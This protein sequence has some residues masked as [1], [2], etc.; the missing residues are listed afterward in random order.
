[1]VRKKVGII[2]IVSNNYGNRLQNYALQEALKRIGGVEPKTIPLKDK[3][4]FQRWLV[5][6]IKYLVDRFIKPIPNITWDEFNFSFI[7][8][9]EKSVDSHKKYLNK[10]YEYFIAGSDQIW[11][12]YFEFVSDRE[13]LMFTTPGK[14]IAYAASIGID[15][16]PEEHVRCYADAW[17]EFRYISV[18][19][20]AAAK[21]IFGNTGQSVDVVLDPTML[22][23]DEEW[24]QF[25]QKSMCEI[26]KKYCLKY[27]LGPVTEEYDRYIENYAKSS[28][29][30]IID[31]IYQNRISKKELSPTDFV[32]LIYNSQAVFTDSFHGS[33]FSII[34]R[35]PLA[36]FERP[37][38][39][40]HGVM[41]SRLDTL[42]ETFHLESQRAKAID[43]LENLHLEWNSENIDVI[44]EKKRIYAIQWL[45]NA[46]NK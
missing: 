15:T 43:D 11:N 39:Q 9:E 10:K 25:A 18:R 6:K 38:Q 27:F 28:N 34:F 45:K 8:W 40:G 29:L 26:D 12:P 23:D 17:K 33:V 13:L 14:R 19:E 4:R 24:K 7:D 31:I 36:V 37:Y 30:E 1:M 42:L 5:L 22:L 32:K 35:K 20:Q 44:L 16:F 46:L 2:T 3:T 41:S 21:I